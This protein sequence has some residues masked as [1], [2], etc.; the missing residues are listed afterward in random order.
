MPSCLKGMSFARLYQLQLPDSFLEILSRFFLRICLAN[1]ILY[2]N[3]NA[4]KCKNARV[5]RRYLATPSGVASFRWAPLLIVQL[6]YVEG[7]SRSIFLC[8]RDLDPIDTPSQVP[9]HFLFPGQ[10]V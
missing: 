6:Y 5:W 3:A 2:R 8:E 10:F 9:G 7:F 4:L 1:F